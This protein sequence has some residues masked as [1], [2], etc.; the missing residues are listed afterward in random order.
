MTPHSRHPIFIQEVV[1]VEFILLKGGNE[2]N[3]SRQVTW[4]RVSSCHVLYEHLISSYYLRRILQSTEAPSPWVLGDLCMNWASHHHT[5]LI[6]PS[7]E[8]PWRNFELPKRATNDISVVHGCSQSSEGI[9]TFGSSQVGILCL[10]VLQLDCLLQFPHNKSCRPPVSPFFMG[11]TQ[12]LAV[13][14]I[15]HLTLFPMLPPK[16][17]IEMVATM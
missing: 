10:V 13:P 14:V 8:M 5:A 2:V 3:M 7:V 1:D 6:A 11:R 15:L 16:V 9:D 17:M 12:E 4:A